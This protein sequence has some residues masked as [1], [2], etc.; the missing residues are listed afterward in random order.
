MDWREAKDSTIGDWKR[1]RDAIGTAEELELLTDINAVC[2]LC[3]VAK[4]EAAGEPDRCGYCLAFQQFG[5]CQAANLAM[6]EMV[7]D[8]NWEK[9]GALVDGFISALEAVDTEAGN[10]AGN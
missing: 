6:T 8:K 10:Q 5:G 9:L 3:V 1:I 2:D 7:M 4:A